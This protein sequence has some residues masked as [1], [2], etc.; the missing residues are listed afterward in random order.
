[1]CKIHTQILS[2]FW[3]VATT[4]GEYQRKERHPYHDRKREMWMKR[5][6]N[7][8]TTILMDVNKRQMT[9]ATC[10]NTYTI[11]LAGC[12]VH[13]QCGWCALAITRSQIMF[14]SVGCCCCCCGCCVRYDQFRKNNVKISQ[15]LLFN[16]I[17]MNNVNLCSDDCSH[18][19]VRSF[20]WS[21]RNAS[22]FVIRC[23]MVKV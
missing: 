21:I 9:T 22:I 15:F 11:P 20:A 8:K 10:I 6:R 19:C 5:W 3:T 1:M 14:T 16:F 12:L 2:C 7:A 18:T 4:S 23:E 13:H 17:H